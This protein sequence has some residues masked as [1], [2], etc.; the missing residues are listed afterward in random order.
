MVKD[1]KLL[2]ELEHIHMEQM[3]NFDNYTNENKTA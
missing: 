1:C 2:I 3:V